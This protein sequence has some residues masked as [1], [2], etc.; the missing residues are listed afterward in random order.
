MPI[1]LDFSF[2]RRNC[3]VPLAF[4]EP[5]SNGATMAVVPVAYPTTANTETSPYAQPHNIYQPILYTSDQYNPTTAPNNQVPQY[6]NYPVGYTYPY[7][8]K[9]KRN[10]TIIHMFHLYFFICLLILIVCYLHNSKGATAYPY[11]SQMTY[12]VPQTVQ[13]PTVTNHSTNSSINANTVNSSNN[14]NNDNSNANKSHITS[15][16]QNQHVNTKSITTPNAVSQANVFQYPT[17]STSTA[18]MT[19][20]NSTTTNSTN[21]AVVVTSVQSL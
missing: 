7:N 15:P 1:Q 10:N 17:P 19:N 9:T 13:T 2:C 20:T 3:S 6:I 11:W 8:G 18:P 21:N 16:Q 12:Y 14:S 5:Q 4:F